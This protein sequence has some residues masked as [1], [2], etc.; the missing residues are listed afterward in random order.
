WV[1]IDD[2][3]FRRYTALNVLSGYA[4]PDLNYFAVSAPEP[5][6]LGSFLLCGWML[7]RR[8]QRPR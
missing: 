7:M 1:R 8:R 4:G 3:S 2:D 5:T 6:T